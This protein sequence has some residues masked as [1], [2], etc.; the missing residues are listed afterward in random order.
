M[1][2]TLLTPSVIAKKALANLYENLCMVPLVYTDVS[3]EWGGQKIGASVAIRKPATFTAQ[4][5]NPSSP[6]ITVQNATETSVSVT[7]DKHRD[8]S[9]AITAQDLTLRLEDFDEQFLMPACEALAQEVDR[10]II[11]QAKADFT[12]V[13]GTGTGFEWNKPEVLIEA[14]RL[15]NIQK[16]PTSERSAVV[17]PTTRAG[18]LNSDIIKHAD[19]SGSTAALREGSIGRGLF[20]FDAYMTQ[21]I[22]QPAGS[23]ASGQPTTEVGLAFHRTALAL[24]SAPLALPRSNTWG[25]MESYKGLSLRVVQD[26]DMNLKSDVI[27]VDIL[28]GT[29]T[30]D[31]NRGVLLRGALAA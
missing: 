17:G 6:S 30:L 8:V 28:F 26:Y 3:S 15:L 7:L 29:K 13:A 21:N 31:A 20:G 9:F 14:D 25:A 22:V 24:A 27:S 4:T 1:A 18:W 16:V 5:F 19:K 10:A 11:A 23:P 2:N 12:A